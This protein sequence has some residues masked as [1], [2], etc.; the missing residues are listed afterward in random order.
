MSA[1]GST[2]GLNLVRIRQFRLDASLYQTTTRGQQSLG[3]QTLYEYDSP[4]RDE[5]RRRQFYCRL[6]A[7]YQAANQICEKLLTVTRY[8]AKP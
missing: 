8:T 3:N 7:S 2:P 4:G 5:K 1:W 6:T